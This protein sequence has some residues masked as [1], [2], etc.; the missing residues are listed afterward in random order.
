MV[1]AAGRLRAKSFTVDGE[2]VCC[3]KRGWRCS[4]CFGRGAAVDCGLVS[5]AQWIP[6]FAELR[7][8]GHA[9]NALVTFW[10]LT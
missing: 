6:A 1:E 8:A 9:I 5:P 4:I 3:D 2:V 7:E 10:G